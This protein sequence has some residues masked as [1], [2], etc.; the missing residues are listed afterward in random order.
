MD[1]LIDTAETIEGL[2]FVRLEHVVAYKRIRA[3]AK[4]QV[5]LEQYRRA[6]GDKQP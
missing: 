6:L 1:E 4:D 2:P 5:H 3:S